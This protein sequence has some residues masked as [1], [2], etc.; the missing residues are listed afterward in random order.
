MKTQPIILV[1]D[2]E[3]AILGLVK[4]ILSPAGYL[5]NTATNGKEALAAIQAHPYD[6]VLTDMV[7][8]QMGGME[9]VQYLRLHHPETLVIVFTGF[10]SYQDAVDAVKL[11]AFDYLPKPLQPE[12]LRHAIERALDYQ[13]LLRSQRD[14]ETVFQGAES[15]GWQAL[16]LVTATPEAAIL[17]ELREEAW[18]QKDLK[19]VGRIFLEAAQK[20][21]QVTNS[22]IFLY[23]AVR[24]Q[25]SGLAALGPDS[26]AKT[27]AMITA[28][29][30]MGYVATHRRPLLVPDLSR[31]SQLSLMPRRTIYQTNSFMVIPLTGYKFWGV[32]NLADREDKSPFSSRDLFLGWLMGRLLVEILEAR[33][34]PEEVFIPS[35]TTW[36]TKEIPV[37]MAFLDQDIKVVRS[38]PALERMAS[39]AKSN[40]VGQNLL[41]CLRLSAADRDSLAQGF[42]QVLASQEPREFFSLKSSPQD[43]GVRYLS[44]KMFPVPD[45]HSARRGLLLVE[46]VTEAEQLKQRLELYE[47][48]AIMGKLTLCVAHELNNPLDGIRRYLSLAIIKK[49][50]PES[51]ERYL[52]EAQKGLQKMAL[53]IKSLM[54][55]ANPFKGPPRA[56]DTVLNLLQDAIKIMMFQASDQRVEVNFSAPPE[57]EKIITEADLYYVFIN[58]IKNALQAMPQGGRLE[59]NCS[60]N[61]LQMEIAFQDSGPG[62][63]AEEMDHIFQPF[64]ST[65]EGAQGLGLGL[66][67]CQKILAR[68]DGRL[69]VESQRGQ[70]TTVRVLLPYAESGVLHGK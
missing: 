13:R 52:S 48:L 9:L 18:P 33:E 41:F 60:L 70:G 32:I 12:I 29:G 11:G 66:P 55:S 51:V 50:D 6:L 45:E 24:G 49:E 53:S 21:L 19:E 3:P 4:D 62:L 20:L 27:G 22:S 14:L 57:F 17:G 58:L 16:E 47:H 25:F 10:A 39:L 1:V 7:M 30:V 23:D 42:Q 65:K 15:L 69:V 37:G 8:P 34:A 44:I 68:Y 2:D 40:L 56:S 26:E 5:V 67:I 63:T 35:L 61:D 36:I 54:F 43:V 59:V 31:D 28:E 64:Y 38:N 46:D